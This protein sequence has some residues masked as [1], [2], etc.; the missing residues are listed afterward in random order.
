MA[1]G[2]GD[3]NCLHRSSTYPRAD[4]GYLIDARGKK[5]KLALFSPDIVLLAKADAIPPFVF[6]Y[7]IIQLLKKVLEKEKKAKIP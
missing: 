6:K 5:R 4:R 1:L 2:P 3:K 7:L